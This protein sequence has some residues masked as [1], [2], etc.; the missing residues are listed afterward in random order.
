MARQGTGTFAGDP[1]RQRNG[2]FGDVERDVIV[3][4]G[5][6]AEHPRVATHRTLAQLLRPVLLTGEPPDRL[7]DELHT[8]HGLVVTDLAQPAPGRGP[9]RDATRFA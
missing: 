6:G 9:Q 2:S 4:F 1:D 3:T 8:G 5:H 7:V